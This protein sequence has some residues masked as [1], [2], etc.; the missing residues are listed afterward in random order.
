MPGEG[1]SIPIHC[2]SNRRMQSV[3]E[4]DD[5]TR[6]ERQEVPEREPWAFETNLQFDAGVFEEVRIPLYINLG[7]SILCKFSRN[8]SGRR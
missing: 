7:C 1:R 4:L 8:V 2:G 3:I 5:L 6:L